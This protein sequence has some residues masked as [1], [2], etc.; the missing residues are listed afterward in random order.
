MRIVKS[1]TIRSHL[2]TL[3]VVALVPLLVFTVAVVLLLNR[4]ERDA[5]ERSTSER[6]HAALGAIDRELTRSLT[7]LEVLASS[8]QLDSDNRR[9]FYDE[10]VSLLRSQPDWTTVSLA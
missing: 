6:A 2:V 10:A 4:S 3:V 8:R 9:G 7:F 1:M 5:L